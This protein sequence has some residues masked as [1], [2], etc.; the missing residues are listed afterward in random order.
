[1]MQDKYFY[2]YQHIAEI[3]IIETLPV[4]IDNIRMLARGVL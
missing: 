4:Y 2:Y 1:M 3:D